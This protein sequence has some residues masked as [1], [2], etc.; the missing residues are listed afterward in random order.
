M[1]LSTLPGKIR[2]KWVLA[3]M[4]VRKEN[5]GWTL[6]DFIKLIHEETMISYLMN[7]RWLHLSSIAYAL[8]IFLE[9]PWPTQTGNKHILIT[10]V[11]S[12]F[13]VIFGLSI[14]FRSFLNITMHSCWMV[15][16]LIIYFGS[17]L[18]YLIKRVNLPDG[19]SILYSTS[20]W[21]STMKWWYSRGFSSNTSR[22]TSGDDY[23]FTKMH[24][25]S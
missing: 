8:I 15:L 1:L 3:V 18:M 13:S 17:P 12:I 19:S 25:T 21:N 6:G 24:N 7:D 22:S 5:K 10:S 2:E 23:C 11:S 14:F 20:L 16:Y 4:D 9:F